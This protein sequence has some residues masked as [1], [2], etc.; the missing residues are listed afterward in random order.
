MYSALRRGVGIGCIRL[1]II[2]M[3]RRQLDEDKISHPR[4]RDPSV[5][6]D[7][8]YMIFDRE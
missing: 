8:V 5:G 1:A 2:P 7:R 3:E 6:I 4:I